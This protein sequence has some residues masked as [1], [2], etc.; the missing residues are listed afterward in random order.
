M[1]SYRDILILPASFD[2]TPSD[3]SSLTQ[4]GTQT[5]YTSLCQA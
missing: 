3:V 4:G 5:T 2:L 1:N